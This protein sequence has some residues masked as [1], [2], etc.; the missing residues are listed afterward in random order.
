MPMINLMIID[1][2]NRQP[3][4]SVHSPENHNHSFALGDNV[5]KQLIHCFI[6]AFSS[7]DII[8]IPSIGEHYW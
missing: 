4:P 3:N 8:N 7:K 6:I 2:A 1:I 5:L